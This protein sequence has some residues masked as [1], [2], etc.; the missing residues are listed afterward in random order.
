MFNNKIP[1]F[2]LKC[3]VIYLSLIFIMSAT[4]LDKA[5]VTKARHCSNYIYNNI[6]GWEKV[7]FNSLTKKY[8]DT[9]IRVYRKK[10]DGNYFA[11]ETNFHFMIFRPM[12]ILITLTIASFISVRKKLWYLLVG[13][14]ILYIIV[15]LMTYIQIWEVIKDGQKML[16]IPV[17]SNIFRVRL[18]EFLFDIFRNPGFSFIIPTIIW[19]CLIIGGREWKS[20][21]AEN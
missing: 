4:G 14:F 6:N 5:F 10:T 20:F 8:Y 11:K 13:L 9:Q 3:M 12:L 15:Y 18:M 21:L 2:V 7:R 19:I 16:K 1:V 17:D